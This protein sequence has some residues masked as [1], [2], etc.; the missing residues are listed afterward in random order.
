MRDLQKLALLCMAWQSLDSADDGLEHALDEWLNSVSV[1]LPQI[2][3]YGEGSR[4]ERMHWF[5]RRLA[6]WAKHQYGTWARAA[7]VLDCDEKT[8]REDMGLKV[9]GEE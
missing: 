7:K 6:E 8:L 5:R 4:K 1:D 3:G 9:F 2:A